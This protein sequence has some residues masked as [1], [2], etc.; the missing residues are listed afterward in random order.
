MTIPGVLGGNPIGQPAVVG[1]YAPYAALAP[2]GHALAAA[3]P[4]AVAGM[5]R[6]LVFSD[7][8]GQAFIGA[9]FD[10]YHRLA[11]RYNGRYATALSYITGTFPWTTVQG[12]TVQGRGMQGQAQQLAPGQTCQSYAMTCDGVRHRWLADPGG[13]AGIL[14]L[15]IDGATVANEDPRTVGNLETVL[16][17]GPHTIG[18]LNTGAGGQTVTVDPPAIFDNNR[19]AGFQVWELS[20]SGYTANDW[21]NSPDLAAMLTEVN[22]HLVG[23]HLGINDTSAGVYPD[24]L[25]QLVQRVRS[26]LQPGLYGEYFVLPW[27]TLGNPQPPVSIAEPLF[28]IPALGVCDTTDAIGSTHRSASFPTCDPL[29]Q[30][31]D[32]V[33]LS[34]PGSRTYNAAVS[35]ML[36]AT[37]APVPAGLGIAAPIPIAGNYTIGPTELVGQPFNVTS[38]APCTI[39]LPPPS[40]LAA[41][42]PAPPGGNGLGSPMRFRQYG[43]GKVTFA[44]GA[45]A[46]IR[47][48]GGLQSIA[49]QYGTAVAEALSPSEWGLSGA[50]TLVA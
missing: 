28:G 6:L 22:P 46:T 43:A 41:G 7:S 4:P 9:N 27:F 14:A 49:G 18:Y 10:A 33:H 47:A 45:G 44:A 35:R 37:L 21:L 5:A 8:E 20:H 50:P 19:T 17:R 30:T 16:T 40:T 29:G 11:L 3:T 36:E 23:Y 12:T 39:T 1:P 42:V 31:I 32:G 26:I 13:A 2:W 34:G 15:Q 24:A 48:V 38:A 25:V